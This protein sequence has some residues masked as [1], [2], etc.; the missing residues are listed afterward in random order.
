MREIKRCQPF[1]KQTKALEQ[2][3]AE[4]NK[5]VVLKKLD[6][7]NF[8]TLLKTRNNEDQKIKGILEF[9]ETIETTLKSLDIIA[10]AF[11]S[12]KNWLYNSKILPSL[13]GYINGMIQPVE[14]NLHLKGELTD[15]NTI[16]FYILDKSSTTITSRDSW[17]ILAKASGFQKAIISIACR[18][19]LNRIGACNIYC[20]G[21]FLE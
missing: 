12:Y 20:D 4:L 10:S 19:G 16:Q 2:E 8:Q 1:Y 21:L 5:Q 15:K 17:I 7:Q 6:L 13:V 9:A 11:G 14:E 18:I 3:L